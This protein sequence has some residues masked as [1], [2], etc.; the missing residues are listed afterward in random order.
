MATE[1]IKKVVIPSANIPASTTVPNSVVL[2][3]RI[4][5][6]DKNRASHWSPIYI[7]PKN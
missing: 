7:L 2:R 5:S 4:I 6:E 3:F 1:N